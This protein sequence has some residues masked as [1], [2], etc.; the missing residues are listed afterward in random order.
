[1]T[2]F[3]ARTR[4]GAAVLGVAGM[5]GLSLVAGPASP[6]GASADVSSSATA[7]APAII[8]GHVAVNGAAL[9]GAKVLPDV[10]PNQATIDAMNGVGTLATRQLSTV[11]TD[12]SG[13]FAVGLDP[14]SLAAKYL[15][16][17]GRPNIELQVVGN[18]K[19]TVWAFTAAKAT[20]GWSVPSKVTSGDLS[21]S[22]AS[23]SFDLGSS[24]SVATTADGADSDRIVTS[25]ESSLETKS[26]SALACYWS[27][28]HRSET[29]R[30]EPFMHVY[31]GKTAAATVTQNYGVDH[32][33]GIAF[34]D[35]SSW[36]GGAAGGTHTISLAA[37]GSKRLLANSTA[38]NALNFE[39][40]VSPCGWTQRVA[41]QVYSI[42]GRIDAA[43]EPNFTNCT[44]YG[45]G[46]TLIK[47]AG[48]NVTYHSQVNVGPVSVNAQSGY[49]SDSSVMWK[50][51][52]TLNGICGSNNGWASAAEAEANSR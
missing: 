10:W 6:A 2:R 44:P 8:T 24:S 9:A 51:G 23:V 1:M 18:G 52:G 41:Y 5:V 12:A 32:A 49:N 47:S 39:D 3:R 4:I 26:G 45:P 40:F 37:S 16:D 21:S 38:F 27:A 17:K 28:P 7:A 20:S 22:P 15:D 36:A 11:V 25:N 50:T 48:T 34:A 42:L 33:V 46:Y 31:P 30:A 14:T 35:G 19:R 29:N 43:A 13:N